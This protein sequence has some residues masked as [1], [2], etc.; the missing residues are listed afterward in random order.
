M[1]WKAIFFTVM[2]LFALPSSV[3]MSGFK[4]GLDDSFEFT[5]SQNYEITNS[6]FSNRSL[7]YWGA[8]EGIIT[9]PAGGKFSVSLADN[10]IENGVKVSI[11]Y[12]N[13]TVT[14]QDSAIGEGFFL[15]ENILDIAESENSSSEQNIQSRIVSNER[16]IRIT[17]DEIQF[18]ITTMMNTTNA[19]FHNSSSISQISSQYLLKTGVLENYTNSF[20]FTSDISSEDSSPGIVSSYLEIIQVDPSIKTVISRF[21]IPWGHSWLCMVLVPLLRRRERNC[22]LL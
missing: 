8:D 19:Y 6:N 14:T 15:P 13:Y 3:Q 20:T 9:I 21:K 12:N 11:T 5:I 2:I 10:S 7:T 22:D 18:R 17:E 16:Q 4:V 1:W